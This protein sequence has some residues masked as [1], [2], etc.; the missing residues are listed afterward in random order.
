MCE[1]LLDPESASSSPSQTSL[2]PLSP[3]TTN[4][5]CEPLTDS[6]VGGETSSL[7]VDDEESSQQTPK[8][9]CLSSH[10]P[11]ELSGLPCSEITPLSSSQSL[12][13][14]ACHVQKEDAL[15]LLLFIH[16]SSSSDVRQMRVEL[17]SDELEVR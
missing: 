9:W 16:N 1:N 4:G 10:V 5:T 12:H 15:I 13:L 7:A 11:A 8:D 17:H 3:S 6:T 2:L 14:S